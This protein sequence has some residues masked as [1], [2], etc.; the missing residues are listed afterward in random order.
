MLTVWQMNSPIRSGS[1]LSTQATWSTVRS[2]LFSA[3]FTS[4]K[5]WNKSEKMGNKGLASLLGHGEL[6]L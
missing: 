3:K 6:L 4:L 2:V 1:Y 5:Y